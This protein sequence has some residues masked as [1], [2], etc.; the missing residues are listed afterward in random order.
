[1]PKT[2]TVVVPLGFLVAGLGLSGVST[3]AQFRR[4]T[5][6]LTPTVQQQAI[7]PGQTVTVELRVELPE[8][9]HVQSDKPRDPYVIPTL[10]T[11]TPPE[12]VTVEEITYPASTDFLLAGWKE[13]LAVFEH[14]FTIEVR[15]ALDAD[16]SPGDMVVPGSFLYQACDDTVC[17]PPATAAV[18]WHIHVEPAER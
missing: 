18:E 16:V 15:L 7:Q 9:I 11:F 14:E 8:D 12:G 10:L 2:R 5:A 6:E 1:M 4:P 13:P 3:S 17:F